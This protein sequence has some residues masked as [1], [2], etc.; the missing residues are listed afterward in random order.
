MS[1]PTCISDNGMI[2]QLTISLNSH[3]GYMWS[4]D[5]NI[6]VMKMTLRILSEHKT[7]LLA[8]RLQCKQ[9]GT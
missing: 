7:H 6:R 8:S 5:I 9:C 4:G 1:P 3:W 2:S